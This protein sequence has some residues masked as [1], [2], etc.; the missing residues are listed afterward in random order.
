MTD[1]YTKYCRIDHC[2][3]ELVS[4]IND[5]P[6][7]ETGEVADQY[8]WTHMDIPLRELEEIVTKRLK[9]LELDA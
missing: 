5:L 2:I 4:S 3:F 1:L 8:G 7:T 6:S 9:K